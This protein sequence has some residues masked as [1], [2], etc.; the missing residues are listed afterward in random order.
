[1]STLNSSD[2]SSAEITDL[3]SAI[4]LLAS[5]P[6][7]FVS[8]DTP[9][10]PYL[11][12]AGVYAP[13]G[14]GTPA[15]PPTRVGPAMLFT[16]VKGF[17]MP[18]V[19]GILASRLRTAHLLGSTIQRLPFTLL[20]ALEHPITP[21]MVVGGEAPCQEVVL[22]PPFDLRSFLPAL[23]MTA[24]D[25]GPY[26]TLGMLRAE[27]PETG[28]SD[29]TIHRLCLQGPDLLSVYFV[30]GRHID[31]FRIKAE[32][33]GRPLPVS[34]N[35][36]LDPATYVAACFEP[37]TTP[38]GFDELTVAGGLRG[39]PVEL[40]DCISVPAKSIAR[41]EI[42][43]EGEI[44]PGERLREDIQTGHG[45]AMPEFPGYLGAAQE[46]LPVMRV[47]TI[48]HR[49]D[50]IFQALVGP[51]EEHTNLVGIPTE[52]SIL[53][54][55]EN[56]MPGR[57]EGVYCHPA[58]GGKYLAIMQFRKRSEDDEGRQRQAALM[59]FA[60]FSELKHVIIVDDDVDIFDTSDVLWAMT[61]RYQ[62]DA[63]T[64]FVPGVRCHPLD[65]TQSPDFNPL[66]PA[67][68]TSCKTIFDCT[69]PYRLKDRFRRAKFVAVERQQ[70]S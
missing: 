33:M 25:A 37:P 57:L 28:E 21:V 1:M 53:R 52:A 59:A 26:I 66:L 14:A 13:L 32:A 29:V 16:N 41:A 6:G 48:T 9:V 17:G 27:D 34:V 18:V 36:G 44:L 23:T 51:G 24:L 43:L 47:T 38:L 10:D 69:V 62:G 45:F 42:V 31:E 63:S 35:I 8:T 60:A 65:P 2:I 49:R 12:L 20:E 30:P 64:V 54:L 11:E 58:G 55:V 46:E 15:P 39:R 40:C 67:A 56:G 70:T 3:R 50:P 68:G 7:Q 22:R 4:D 19:T 5:L 61:T